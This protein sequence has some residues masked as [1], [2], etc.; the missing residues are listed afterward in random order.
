MPNHWAQWGLTQDDYGR[1]F[2]SSN[3]DPALSIQIPRIYWDHIKRASG[4]NPRFIPSV[5]DAYDPGFLECANL[6]KT[7]DRGGVAP[8]RTR[9]TSACGQTVFRGDRLPPDIRGDYF[10]CD[11]TIHVV[12]RAT[13]EDQN[14][15][16]HLSNPYGN[17]EFLLSSD[18]N[19]RPVNTAMG[20]DGCL[21]VVDMY[22]GII[23][24]E[25]WYNDDAK[26]FARDSG[27]VNHIQHGRIWRIRHQDH[28]PDQSP[29][30]LEESTASLIRHFE[31]R[32]GWE[33]DTAQKLILLRE[34]RETVAP[35]LKGIVR[36]DPY[37]PMVRLHALWTLEGMDQ[38][39]PALLGEVITQ[40][41]DPSVRAAAIQIAE[42]L[43]KSGDTAILDLL[44]SRLEEEKDP[45][46]AKQM[47]LSLGWSD[48]PQALELIEKLASR[49]LTHQGVFLASMTSLWGKENS[50]LIQGI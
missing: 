18:F 30:M 24:D 14:G 31:S 6:A 39:D 34:D 11:P 44:A 13:I 45:E 25:P 33:R 29:R 5:G 28:H 42:P 50:K 9:F 8:E 48:S 46:V 37:A 47:I 2:Y 17:G 4:S 36:F 22:R 10:V 43:I 26:Q 3:S 38:A 15:K 21:Y 1:I 20:P 32:N 23:Q 12:R 41:R 40:D 16:L 7:A 49:H 27:I 19:F 35:L